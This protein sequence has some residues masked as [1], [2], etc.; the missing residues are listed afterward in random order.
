MRLRQNQQYNVGECL[1]YTGIDIILVEEPH[2]QVHDGITQVKA[3]RNVQ[4]ISILIWDH[5]GKR[6]KL[7]CNIT[8]AHVKIMDSLRDSKLNHD[9]IG[10]K[11]L[12]KKYNTILSSLLWNVIWVLLLKLLTDNADVF[13]TLDDDLKYPTT[14]MKLY[15]DTGDDKLID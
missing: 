9:K 11:K 6:V 15:I 3:R 13:A 12:T 4:Y 10:W 5:S 2:I 8:L 14:L 1:Y 7:P